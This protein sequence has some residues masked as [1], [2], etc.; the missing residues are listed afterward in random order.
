LP[1]CDVWFDKTAELALSGVSI[2]LA[3][4][5][6]IMRHH[7][8]VMGNADIVWDAGQGE[9]VLTATVSG[10]GSLLCDDMYLLTTASSWAVHKILW[11]GQHTVCE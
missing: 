3:A 8:D 9:A 1:D 7:H 5:G 2:A 10:K 11:S 4:K 6:R